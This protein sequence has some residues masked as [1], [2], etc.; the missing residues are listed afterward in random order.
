M[1]SPGNSQKAILSGLQTI[2]FLWIGRLKTKVEPFSKLL[3]AQFEQIQWGGVRLTKLCS[4][5]AQLVFEH[6]IYRIINL[7]NKAFYVCF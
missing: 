6:D 4:F 1:Q 7:S 5:T 3:W 2:A